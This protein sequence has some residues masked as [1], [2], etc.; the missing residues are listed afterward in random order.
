MLELIRY[1]HLNPVRSGVKSRPADYPWSAH[2]AYLGTVSCGWLTTG[3]VLRRFAKHRNK[4]REEYGRFVSKAVPQQYREEFHLGSREGIILGDDDFVASLPRYAASVLEKKSTRIELSTI[5]QAV[6]RYYRIE[7]TVLM[8]RQQLRMPA[9]IRAYVAFLFTE[10]SGSIREAARYY[11]R[12]ISTLSR[13]LVNLK[14]RLTSDS[15]LQEEM[16]Q[17]K[18]C[19][20][21]IAQA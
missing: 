2:N 11:A 6:C 9:Q 15:E 12:D 16:D 1:I 13:Q 18:E 19:V 7:E 10:N 20:N 14:Q 3:W 5:S 4:A 17:L 21:A 8:K